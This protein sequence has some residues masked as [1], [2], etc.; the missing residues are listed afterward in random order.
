MIY[1]KISKVVRD[2]LPTGTILN[3]INEYSLELKLPYGSVSNSMKLLVVL[4]E[5]EREYIYCHYGI[6][7][8]FYHIDNLKQTRFN[9]DHCDKMVILIELNKTKLEQRKKI[10]DKIIYK[11]F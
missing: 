11:I 2:I 5:L 9:I 1:N 7:E 4:D 8:Y 6:G 3:K 10:I